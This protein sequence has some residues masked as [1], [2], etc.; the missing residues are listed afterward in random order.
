MKWT[1]STV[2]VVMLILAES[3]QKPVQIPK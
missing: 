3:L 1:F 2:S